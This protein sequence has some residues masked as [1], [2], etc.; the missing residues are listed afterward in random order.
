LSL[1]FGYL[2][3][4][5]YAPA[6]YYVAEALQLLGFSA[7]HALQLLSAALIVGAGVTTYFFAT[8][9]LRV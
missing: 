7:Y 6:T 9:P 3:F 8:R 4:S 5:Y 2:F 1:G